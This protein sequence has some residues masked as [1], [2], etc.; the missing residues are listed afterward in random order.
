ML[1]S[2]FSHRNMSHMGRP[3][4]PLLPRSGPLRDH[5]PILP[6][7]EGAGRI[8]AKWEEQDAHNRE[9]DAEVFGIKEALDDKFA[10]VFKKLSALQV[11][12][13]VLSAIAAGVGSV[14]GKFLF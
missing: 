5:A 2:P 12:V 1:G 11:K 4:W 8:N 10:A 13:A 14:V 6:V 9:V 3:A 7:D